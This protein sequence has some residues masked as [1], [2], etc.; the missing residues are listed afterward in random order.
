M[1]SVFSPFGLGILD[2]AVGQWAAELAR[3]ARLDT[4]IHSFLPPASAGQEIPNDRR[5]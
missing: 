1:T 4:H 5:S 2:I 3:A